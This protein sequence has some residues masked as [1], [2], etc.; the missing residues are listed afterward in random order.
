MCTLPT[1]L[2]SGPISEEWH[3]PNKGSL[4]GEQTKL[5][6]FLGN[7]PMAR[8]IFERNL[9]LTWIDC[10]LCTLKIMHRVCKF[11]LDFTCRILFLVALM[12]LWTRATIFL[13]ILKGVAL[14][15][16]NQTAVLSSAISAILPSAVLYVVSHVSF[17]NS[18]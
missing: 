1:R 5:K 13:D 7:S 8:I 16:Q 2:E 12:L 4:Y 17:F 11:S 18:E 15:L 14:L 10:T 3:G 9:S 6:C